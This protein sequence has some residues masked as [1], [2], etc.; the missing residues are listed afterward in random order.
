MRRLRNRPE[1]RAWRAVMICSRAAATA[2]CRSMP[3]S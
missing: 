2:P 3:R 1:R